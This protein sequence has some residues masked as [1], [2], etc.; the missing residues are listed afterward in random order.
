MFNLTTNALLYSIII[1]MPGRRVPLAPLFGTLAQTSGSSRS[2]ML[3]V[4]WQDQIRKA[5]DHEIYEHKING[6][7]TIFTAYTS[8]QPT[9]E[10]RLMSTAET[11]KLH[12]IRSTLSA[13]LCSVPRI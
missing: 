13:F 7:I 12:P 8:D 2:A 9:H 11:M 3:K 10:I 1:I 4:P 6:E 5:I